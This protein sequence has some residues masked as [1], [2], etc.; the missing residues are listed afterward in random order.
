MCHFNDCISRV[1]PYKNNNSF[2][3]VHIFK[4]SQSIYGNCRTR[5]TILVPFMIITSIDTITQRCIFKNLYQDASIKTK[6][7]E[8]LRNL[9]FIFTFL[10]PVSQQQYICVYVRN[11]V[12]KILNKKKGWRLALIML[13]EFSTNKIF[14]AKMPTKVIK[15]IHASYC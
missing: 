12:E 7:N 11:Y 1:I 8:K 4:I 3:S 13:K 6:L 14:S 9:F 15:S 2:R 5:Y 10:L